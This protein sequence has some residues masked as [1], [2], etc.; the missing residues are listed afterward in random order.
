MTNQSST[1][2]KTNYIGPFIFMVLLMALI[3]FVTNLNQQFQEPLKHAFLQQAEE[4][5]NTLGQMFVFSF[6]LAYLLIG[7]LAS[8]FLNRHGYKRTLTVGLLGVILS[9]IIF[10][11]STMI[12]HYTAVPASEH[13]SESLT[14]IPILG[15]HLPLSFFIFLLGSFT[16]GA[17]LTFLQASVNP[18]LVVCD[19]PHTTGVTRQNIAGTFN[20]LMNTVTPLLVAWVVFGG[21]DS[22]SIQVGAMIIPFAVLVGLLILL[23]IG[24]RLVKLP[25]LAE[26]MQTR[27]ARLEHSVWSFRHLSLGAVAIFMYVGCEVCIGNN[28]IPF[29]T[30]DLGVDYGQAAQWCAYYWGTMLVGR[31][32][33]SFLTT[34]HARWQLAIA[35]IMAS[36]LIVAAMATQN[37]RW[38][39]AVGVFHSVIWGAIFTLALHGLGKYTAKASGVLLMGVVGGAILPLVQGMLADRLQSWEY[40]WLLVILGEVYM[41]SYA[42]WGSRVH[43]TAKQLG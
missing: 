40:T 18:Y 42:L 13:Y 23:Y 22:K 31:F 6:F 1:T 4:A 28:I 41:L 14:H 26:T 43:K 11:A 27:E 36:I 25:E 24:V 5:S 37:A 29:A 38:L 17:G 8:N 10:E 34:V 32:I 3:G 21:V 7:P 30:R 39:I 12:Y 20:S 19:V 35:T 9:V 2:P 16:S 15:V 33:S